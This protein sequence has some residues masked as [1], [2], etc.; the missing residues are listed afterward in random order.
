MTTATSEKKSERKKRH[1]GGQQKKKFDIFHT[2]RTAADGGGAVGD[3][4]LLAPRQFFFCGLRVVRLSFG[5]VW[6]TTARFASLS[7]L[8]ALC[9]LFFNTRTHTEK[10]EW[11]NMLN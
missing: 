11:E 8:A 5:L 1:R 6:S 10:P 2:E 7:G 3:Y 4:L 9:D